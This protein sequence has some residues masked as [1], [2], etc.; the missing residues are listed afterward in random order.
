MKNEYTVY[1]YNIG[2]SMPH[3]IFT[4][5]NMVKSINNVHKSIKKSFEDLTLKEC[6]AVGYTWNTAKV[7]KVE[8]EFGLENISDFFIREWDYK[9]TD[10][11]LKEEFPGCYNQ[12]EVQ[13]AWIRAKFLKRMCKIDWAERIV[14]RRLPLK[15]VSVF[16][17]FSLQTSTHSCLAYPIK[18]YILGSSSEDTIDSYKGILPMTA[19]VNDA[20]GKLY[21][22][23]LSQYQATLLCHRIAHEC[24][25]SPMEINTALWLLGS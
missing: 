2:V 25:M 11:S 6:F 1:S 17:D 8:N 4:N 19:P 15:N 10:E 20:I 16:E 5:D 3:E 22:T 18:C 23:Q 12:I 7:E 13:N 21:R 9:K 14:E 24:E